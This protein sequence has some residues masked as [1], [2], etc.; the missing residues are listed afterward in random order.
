M[1]KEKKEIPREKLMIF[2][3]KQKLQLKQHDDAHK[4]LRDLVG[5]ALGPASGAEADG[6]DNVI[7]GVR[8]LATRPAD[9]TA[10]KAL[11]GSPPQEEI[12]W[13]DD[14]LKSRGERM[15]EMSVELD[16]RKRRIEELEAKTAGNDASSM[17]LQRMVETA[18]QKLEQV[19]VRVRVC[20]CVCVCVRV[21]VCVHPA[22]TDGM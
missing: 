19:R 12:Q 20:V 13:R 7:E 15:R 8:A 10:A 17:D 1:S 4:T 14:E 9:G 2:I 21:C 5:E 16:V 11:V 6:W 3:K 18:S 22:C